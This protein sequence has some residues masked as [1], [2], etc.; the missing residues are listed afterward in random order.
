MYRVD[1]LAPLMRA[2]QAGELAAFEQLYG[3]LAGELQAYFLA[4]VRD[5]SVAR[6]LVQDT[7]LEVHRSRH[8]YLPSLPVRPWLFGIARHIL[9]RHRRGAW[10]RAM[11]EEPLAEQSVAVPPRV[12]RHDLARALVQLPASRREPFVL[13]HIHGL[14][15]QQIA[16]RIGIG[17]VAAKL[18]SSRAM[19]ALREALGDSRHDE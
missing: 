13:H 15:F 3:R 7:F 2:Y 17:V 16:E 14:S 4:S 6:D 11:H 18:R 19:R 9:G 12:E 1:D 8:T 5:A 10:R